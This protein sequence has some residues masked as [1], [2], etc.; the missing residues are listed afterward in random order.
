MSEVS[1]DEPFVLSQLSLDVPDMVATD[2]TTP[3]KQGRKKDKK[4]KKKSRKDTREPVEKKKDAAVT[5]REKF[6]ELGDIELLTKLENVSE[7]LESIRSEVRIRKN[8]IFMPGESN[9]R[10]GDSS[11]FDDLYA[12]RTYQADETTYSVVSRMDSAPSASPGSAILANLREAL[13]Y[14]ADPS[15]S[16]LDGREVAELLSNC[17]INQTFGDVTLVYIMEAVFGRLSFRKLTANQKTVLGILL[18]VSGYG[19]LPFRLDSKL[20]DEEHSKFG[21]IL[22]AVYESIKGLLEKRRN[23]F[24]SGEENACTTLINSY[25]KGLCNAEFSLTTLFHANQVG[26]TRNIAPYNPLDDARFTLYALAYTD[27]DGGRPEANYVPVRP[28]LMLRHMG[29]HPLNDTLINDKDNKP[30]VL[31]SLVQQVSTLLSLGY[32]PLKFISYMTVCSG[33]TSEL[34]GNALDVMRLLHDLVVVVSQ[35]GDNEGLT[36]SEVQRILERI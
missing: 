10:V 29:V 19:M 24:V 16:T 22:D 18:T 25:I 34:R 2:F 5:S 12:F 3:D 28:S 8:R 32:N 15:F 6:S 17:L 26:T 27:S 1:D 31:G 33:F 11:R 23:L 9:D 13:Y 36:Q 30:P 35:K 21:A 14:N 20:S 7:L 4:D